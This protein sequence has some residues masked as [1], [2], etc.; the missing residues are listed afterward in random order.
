MARGRVAEAGVEGLLEAIDDAVA[1]GVVQ[2]RP[3]KGNVIP[4]V[5]LSWLAMAAGLAFCTVVGVPRSSVES[6]RRGRPRP[7]LRFRRASFPAPGK[8]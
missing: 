4:G 2:G 3:G 8:R 5:P 6:I 1:I 7:G